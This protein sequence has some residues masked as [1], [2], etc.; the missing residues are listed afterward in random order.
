MQKPHYIYALIDPDNFSAKYVGV[1]ASPFSRF[2]CHMSQGRD[3][4]VGAQV[5]N[6]RKKEWILSLRKR[7]LKPML[8]ILE[9]IRKEDRE[10]KEMAWIKSLR[11]KS[12]LFNQYK[13]GE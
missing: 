13:Y 2:S 5:E 3:D 8:L 12:E 9:K 4:C 7:G 6:K 1:T 11:S 10:Q